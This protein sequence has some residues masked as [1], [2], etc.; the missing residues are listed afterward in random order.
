MRRFMCFD[1]RILLRNGV[2]L[3][4]TEKTSYFTLSGIGFQ[5]RTN[6]PRKSLKN[7][8]LWVNGWEDFNIGGWQEPTYFV[9]HDSDNN[10]GICTLVGLVKNEN[11]QNLTLP[12]VQLPK[13]VVRK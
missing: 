9:S 6:K 3:G 7:L 4:A 8:G 1:G 12:M 13:N 11:A 10:V 5:I 2:R